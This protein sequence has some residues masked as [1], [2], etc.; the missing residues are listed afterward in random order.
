MLSD[1]LLFIFPLMFVSLAFFCHQIVFP[2]I[3][4][5]PLFYGFVFQSVQSLEFWKWCRG[6]CCNILIAMLFSVFWVQILCC[7]RRLKLFLVIHLPPPDTGRKGNMIQ[8]ICWLVDL[9]CLTALSKIFQL[10]R[11][12]KFYWWRKLEF[13]EKTI[14]QSQV[15]DKLYH[16][17]CIEHKSLEWTSNSQL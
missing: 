11:G 1:T 15:T 17:M 12:G 6:C 8:L 2:L 9:W 3:G 14:D 13:P 7:T 5:L 4:M 10:Y 16:I